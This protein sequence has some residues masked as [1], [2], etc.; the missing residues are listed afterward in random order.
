[1][2][3]LD[4]PRLWVTLTGA[5]ALILTACGPAAVATQSPTAPASTVAP[6]AAPAT[7]VPTAT[8]AAVT[9]LFTFDKDAVV[10][11][12]IAGT[13][14][15]YI[16]PG[17]V[18]EAAGVLHMFA[19]SFSAWPGPMLV[20]HLTSTDGKTWTLDKKA[21][22]LDSKTFKLADPGIDVS[23]GYVAPDG[24]WVLFYETVS[25]THPWVVARAIAS[26]PGGPWAIEDKPVVTPGA[27]GT[28]DAGGVTWPSVI[29][30]GPAGRCTTRAS[31]SS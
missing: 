18:I 23:T 2:S 28:F 10:T 17:A 19:N 30:I 25:S 15:L 14:D 21:A 22:P 13:T 9:K 12:A 4:A 1:M 7:D 16:N 6:T 29:K 8:P 3:N 20:P 11:A 31:M 26:G 5:L 24:S 27:A